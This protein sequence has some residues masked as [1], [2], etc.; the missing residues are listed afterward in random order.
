MA[1][2]DG[3]N[4]L[5]R[6]NE[7]LKKITESMSYTPE[8]ILEASIGANLDIVQM[9]MQSAQSES[10]DLTE[11]DILCINVMSVLRVFNATER[12]QDIRNLG[13]FL[14]G[15]VYASVVPTRADSTVGDLITELP[16]QYKRY[17]HLCAV[18][19]GTTQKL[20]E[21]RTNRS[22]DARS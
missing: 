20:D 4:G 13:C 6:I 11:L 10:T 12:Q 16:E 22:Q 9:N 21:D 3:L 17:A 7:L 8:Q 5:D 15:L 18:I 2:T 1:S 14:T 19:E